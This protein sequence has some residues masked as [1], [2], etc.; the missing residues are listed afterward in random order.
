MKILVI[1]DETDLLESMVSFLREEGFICEK[2]ANFQSA[3]DKLAGFVYDVVILDI[4]LPDGNGLN[5]LKSI[6]E[7]YPETGTLI[8]SA[9]NSLDDKINGLDL[10]ADDYITKPF[11]LTELHSRIRAVLRRRKFQ[12]SKAVEFQEIKLIPEE[13]TVYVH[14]QILSLTPKEYQLLLFFMTN[15]ERV[16]TRQ[17]IAEHLWGDYMDNADHFDFVY[18]HLNNLR[19]KIKASGGNDYISTVYGIGYKFS[20]S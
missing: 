20:A 16:L 4:T 17:S 13:R 3:E 18:T 7:L 8:V 1:E 12:G 6:K 5:L 2:A 14:D 10:G 9:R 15:K 11:H 19:K